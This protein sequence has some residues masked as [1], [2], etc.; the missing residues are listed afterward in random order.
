MMKSSTS[1][2]SG[3]KTKTGL[4][5]PLE[6]TGFPGDPR[7][8][9]Q[10][11]LQGW[12]SPREPTSAS[13]SCL[14]V[15]LLWGCLPWCVFIP[16]PSSVAPSLSSLHYLPSL[17]PPSWIWL[18]FRPLGAFR[19]PAPMTMESAGLGWEPDCRS[20]SE[21]PGDSNTQLSEN[22]KE[23]GRAQP[24]AYSGPRFLICKMGQ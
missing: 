20:L 5:F 17:L 14:E 2:L 8:E 16:S 22:C 19:T 15:S 10:C 6:V 21:I 12:P 9:L 24:S 4:G 7:G 23:R 13:A 11:C 18:R 1:A 3:D